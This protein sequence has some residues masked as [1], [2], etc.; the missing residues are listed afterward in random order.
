MGQSVTG[1]NIG[2]DMVSDELLLLHASRTGRAD[3]LEQ[4]LLHAEPMR[5]NELRESKTQVSLQLALVSR[6]Q[7]TF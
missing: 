6:W 3:V 2:S 1:P 4:I 5:L 7:I